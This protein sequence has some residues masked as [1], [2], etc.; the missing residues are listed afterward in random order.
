MKHA[1]TLSIDIISKDLAHA[2]FISALLPACFGLV[3]FRNALI[4]LRPRA[5]FLK[6]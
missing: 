3:D 4:D 6:I 1:L 2:F 5:F